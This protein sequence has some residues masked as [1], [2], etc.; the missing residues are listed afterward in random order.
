LRGNECHAPAKLRR[1]DRHLVEPAQIVSYP[2]VSY[3]RHGTET[4]AR[5]NLRQLHRLL[6]LT[7]VARYG[8]T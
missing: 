6:D 3:P 8:N 7:G 5:E 2:L 4:L 1:D